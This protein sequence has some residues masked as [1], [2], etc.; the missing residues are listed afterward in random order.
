MVKRKKVSKNLGK[1]LRNA[2]NLKKD[3][4]LHLISHPKLCSPM[5]VF[6]LDKFL[7][8]VNSKYAIE[9]DV[10]RIGSI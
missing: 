8:K 10:F 6:A 9:S 7:S 4:F 2:K 1:I 5:N 3:D